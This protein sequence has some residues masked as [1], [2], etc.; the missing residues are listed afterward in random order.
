MSTLDLFAGAGGASL[1][2][3]GLDAPALTDVLRRHRLTVPATL[4]S[5]P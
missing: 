3:T 1:R 5:T 2:A 4:G